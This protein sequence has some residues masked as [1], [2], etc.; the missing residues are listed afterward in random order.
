MRLARNV[1]PIETKVYSGLKILM[2][3]NTYGSSDIVSVSAIMIYRECGAPE[4]AGR[5]EKG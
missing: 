1:A 4:R 2:C 3:K 5:D